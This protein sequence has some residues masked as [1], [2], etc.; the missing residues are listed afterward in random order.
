MKGSVFDVLII[1]LVIFSVA[2]IGI[3]GNV[4]LT[5]VESV[6]NTSGAL[7]NQ[8]LSILQKGIRAER[9]FDDILPFILIGLIASSAVLAFLIP[10][11]P[12]LIVPAIF[13]LV[14]I[15]MISGQLANAYNTIVT[16]EILVAEAN[17]W[18]IAN[19]MMRNLPLIA[20]ISGIIIMIAM[21]ALSR[22]NQVIAA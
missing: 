7:N 11:H 4:V 14:I 17:Q 21:F 8:S 9:T 19:L 12:V 16:N 1:I 22:R 2:I 13:S 20:T 10:S 18:D 15:V 3:V 6:T 5:R